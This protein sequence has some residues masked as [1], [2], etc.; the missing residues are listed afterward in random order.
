MP[1]RSDSAD[2]PESSRAP[3]ADAP[4]DKPTGP[5]T[6]SAPRAAASE[7]PPPDPVLSHVPTPDEEGREPSPR[8]GVPRF[9]W[10]RRFLLNEKHG[11]EHKTY[12]WYNVLWLTG[13]DYF[14][15]L[16][17]QPGI[18]FLAAGLLAPVATLVLVAVTL[19]GA[20]PV[21]SQ[22]ARRSHSGQGS[23]AMLERLLP[24]WKGKLFVL[25]LLGFASTDF[26]I[27]MT[28]SSADAAQH[29]VENPLLNGVLGGHNMAV[30]IVLLALLAVVFL[31]GFTEA[32]S[33]AV[34]AG[35]PY[36]LLNVVVVV[37]GLAELAAHPDKL[38]GWFSTLLADPKIHGDYTMLVVGAA[39]AFPQLALGMSGFETGV[40]VMPLVR[41]DTGDDEQN[42][43]GRIRNT[44]RL[45]GSAAVAMSAMLIASSL[46]TSVLIPAAEF[47]DGGKASGRALAYLAHALLG[48]GFGSVYDLSTII[49]LWFAGASAMA[50]L[51]SLLPRYLPRFGMAPEWAGHVRPL[52]V[53][54]FVI[55]VVVTWIFKADV[56]AQGGAYATGML[57]LIL[58]A[59]V[60]VT[61][62]VAREE[63]GT[64]RL[65]GRLFYGAIVLVMGYTLVVN[66]A[67][68]PDGVIIASV[69]IFAMMLTSGFSRWRRS[70]ELRVQNLNFVDEESRLLWYAM[71]GKQINLVPVRTLEGERRREKARRLRKHYRHILPYAFLHVELADD[72]SD[73]NADIQARVRVEGDEFH[74]IITGAVAVANTIAWVSEQLD[75]IGLYLELSLRS[76][77]EQAISYLLFGEGETGMMVHQILVRHWHSTREND[78]RPLIFLVT[79]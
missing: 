58:S 32:I 67:E 30:T 68:R 62:A 11:S 42:P 65:R 4:A 48:E 21:Y 52:V 5:A 26:V 74:I 8:A 16:G 66:V 38:H 72:P 47:Q 33:V 44:R 55:D 64:G 28:L 17:Y 77:F 60:A 25:A 18:A 14:S 53:I 31:A 27:T 76:Q 54:L 40:S 36:L 46:A 51:L 3:S 49:I 12:P 41:G 7:L 9:A 6:T 2:S 79:P 56:N 39:I 23:I 15:T 73:F 22:V 43:A 69:F 10:L 20:L 70:T 57:V 35:V 29:A 45:L 71:K 75:P 37:R 19:A 50:G 24:G 1:P 34:L 63:R 59:A 13:V 61:I 78:V